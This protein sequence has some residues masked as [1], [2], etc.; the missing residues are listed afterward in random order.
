MN[1]IT[2]VV[3]LLAL[4][5]SAILTVDGFATGTLS[6]L[7]SSVEQIQ[8]GSRV[9]SESN[10]SGGDGSSSSSGGN[11]QLQQ[12]EFKIYPDGRVGEKVMGVKGADCLKVTEKINEQLGKVISTTPTEE[13][14]E[15]EL[16]IEQTNTL[17]VEDGQDGT[18][19][20]SSSS[21]TSWEGSSSWWAEEFVP[22][23][24]ATLTTTPHCYTIRTVEMVQ[25]T[26]LIGVK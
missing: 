20:S 3:L 14:H 22:T 25:Q 10:W 9:Y 24:A 8:N 2:C 1:G 19:S 6:V 17:Y 7:S 26:T 21:T 18:G 16:Q 11:G 13:M 12:I 15:Q 5:L 23:P 4:T